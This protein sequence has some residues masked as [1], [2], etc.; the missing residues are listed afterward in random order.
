MK[1]NDS[2]QYKRVAL[3]AGA[4]KGTNYLSH[5]NKTTNK[6]MPRAKWETRA[7]ITQLLGS[8]WCVLPDAHPSLFYV[9]TF[10]PPDTTATTTCRLRPPSSSLDLRIAPRLRRSR[11]VA[12]CPSPRAAAEHQPASEQWRRGAWAW[13]CRRGRRASAPAPAGAGAA[14]SR[15][16]G[17]WESL[18][19]RELRLPCGL[20]GPSPSHRSVR[21]NRPEVQAP[22]PLCFLHYTCCGQIGVIRHFFCLPC[23]FFNSVR[24][25]RV[26]AIG[27]YLGSP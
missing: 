7:R 21:R 2:S 3:G 4:G 25:N 13:R 24:S 23:R 8:V 26:N 14:C 9:P 16:S 6:E 22:S 20:A 10:P 18:T 27:A 15:P 19:R 11:L 17:A 12:A 1:L 5:H